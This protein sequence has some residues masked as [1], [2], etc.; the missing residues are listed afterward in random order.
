LINF[1]GLA[2]LLFGVFVDMT[3]GLAHIA[4]SEESL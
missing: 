4:W 2:I 3:V 1:T